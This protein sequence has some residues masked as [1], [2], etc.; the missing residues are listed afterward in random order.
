MSEKKFNSKKFRSFLRYFGGDIQ[1]EIITKEDGT[2]RVIIK[3][4]SLMG[5]DRRGRNIWF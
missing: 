1:H 5:T 3:P 2:K 4:K